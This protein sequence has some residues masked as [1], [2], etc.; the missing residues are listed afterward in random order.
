MAEDGSEN[1]LS[2]DEIIDEI[3][4]FDLIN[5]NWNE[6]NSDIYISMT[7]H[8]LALDRHIGVAK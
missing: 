2:G 3:G 5:I 1:E 6:K 7:I 8:V 4:E